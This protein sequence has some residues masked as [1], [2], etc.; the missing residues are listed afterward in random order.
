MAC[1][2]V[3]SLCLERQFSCQYLSYAFLTFTI[4]LCIAYIC[5]IYFLSSTV[6]LEIIDKIKRRICREL[7][8]RQI[9]ARLS[10]LVIRHPDFKRS[11]CSDHFTFEITR[12]SL[13][14]TALTAFSLME[15]ATEFLIS[16]KL[17]KL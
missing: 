7:A 6:Y 13:V 14:T 15:H 16:C 9:S 4:R 8:S 10:T 17:H 3:D 5:D 12:W 1:M 2:E 11:A